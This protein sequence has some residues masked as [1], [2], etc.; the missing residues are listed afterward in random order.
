MELSSLARERCYY[1]PPGTVNNN[2]RLVIV[3]SC[4]VDDLT[5]IRK[6]K[7]WA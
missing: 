2:N 6:P 1:I 4:C 5:H 7:S 3:S